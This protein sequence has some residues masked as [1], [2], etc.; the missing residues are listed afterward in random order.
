MS[1]AAL[2]QI[3]MF[4]PDTYFRPDALRGDPAEV[5]ALLED[6]LKAEYPIIGKIVPGLY[7]REPDRISRRY[8]NTALNH[9]RMARTLLPPGSGLAGYSALW[10]TGWS[11]QWTVRHTFAS[12]TSCA[13]TSPR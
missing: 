6:L 4:Q 1:D 11:T 10:A 3:T 8:G 7:Y 2:K 5:D 13:L 12:V 9:E